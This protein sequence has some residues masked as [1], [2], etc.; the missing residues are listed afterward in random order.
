MNQLM[1]NVLMTGQIESDRL[2]FVPAA[3]NLQ[4]LCQ[5]LVDEC[6]VN[7]SDAHEMVFTCPEDALKTWMDENLLRLIFSNLLNNAI[8]YSPTGGC[9]DFSY[10]Y[11]TAG[12]NVIFEVKD[13]GIGIPKS[14]QTNLFESFFRAFNTKSIQGTGL[15][16]AIVRQCVELHQG[17]M[18]LTSEINVGTTVTITLPRIYQP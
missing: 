18:A 7:L 10:S 5:N 3:I 4:Q 1:E 6:S 14:E 8:K 9:I 15:G 12:Q 11:A 2:R 16:L 13:Q 17:Y